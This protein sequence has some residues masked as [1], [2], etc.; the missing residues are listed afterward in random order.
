MAKRKMSKKVA[1][2]RL[3]R[4]VSIGRKAIKAPGEAALK[5]AERALNNAEKIVRQLDRSH[6]GITVCG[7]KTTKNFDRLMTRVER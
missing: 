4:A 2:N 3:R 1:C 6:G 5:K 7:P